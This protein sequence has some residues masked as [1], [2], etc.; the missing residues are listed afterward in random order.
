MSFGSPLLL[1]TLLALPLI[2]LGYVWLRRRPARYAVRYTNLDVLAGVAA[3]SR[4]WRR[5][6]GLA[7]FLL[8]LAALLVGFARP[9]MTRL[10]DREEATVVLV[11]DV[12][13]SM[14]A[15]DVAPTRLEAAQDVMRQFIEKLPPRFQ[16]GLVAFSEQ[17][18]V[19]APATDDHDFVI[20][21]ISYLYPQR[22]TNIGDAIARA[23]QVVRAAPVT[24][25]EPGAKKE[26]QA[27]AAILLLSDGS[28]TVG[29]L[30][31]LQGAQRAKSFKIP[32]YTVAL[33]T[34]EGLIELNRFGVNRVIPVPPDAATL[35]QIAS[36][37]G[38]KA[39][40][41]KSVA[42]LNEAY[43]K[44]GSL[45]SKVER[46]EEVTVAFLAVGLVLLLA[47]AA[48]ARADVP[49]AAVRRLAPLL[50][51]VL[52]VT[53]CSGDDD[54]TGSATTVT[55]Q[56]TATES[57]EAPNASTVGSIADAVAE[58]LPSVVYVR[59]TVVGGGNGEGSGVVVDRAGIIV[60][61][62]HVVEGAN[63]IEITF[64][65]GRHRRPLVGTVIG[66]AAERDLAVVR[67][68]ARDLVPIRIA[69]SS[70]LRLGD[71]VIAVGYPLGLGGP[72]VTSGIVSG[73]EP[74]GRAGRRAAAGGAAPDGRGDQPRQLGRRARR[75]GRTARRDQHR[76]GTRRRGGEHRLRDRDRRGVADHRGDP[77]RARGDAG[78]ARDLDLRPSSRT[79]PRSR[80]GS[81]PR[82]AASG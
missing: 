58:V 13:G 32:V 3:S 17:A 15:K 1:L 72:T 77:E 47:A 30:S 24:P 76:G 50:L 29:L 42:G 60:T 73:P 45:V 54:S 16:V 62:N 4:S 57:G 70:S 27:P 51:A 79:R 34:P 19:V 35:R 7:L 21:S 28:Q 78:L 67:V 26:K 66:T 12:S 41:A 65:D 64:N 36:T 5:H 71:D 10:A 40:E 75:P 25:A 8:A 2:V 43:E 48:V 38:G 81:I 63:E 20:D 37:T 9:S 22:G 31:P 33:G 6:A 56:A 18:E 61:N 69:R 68:A 53:G 49:E 11:V 80:S 82:R 23:V 44:L 55:V 14:Q 39:Y 59:T 52:V 46:D 74:D